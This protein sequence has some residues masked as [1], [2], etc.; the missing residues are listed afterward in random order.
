LFQS[1]P[2][3]RA[4]HGSLIV[5]LLQVIKGIKKD[6]QRSSESVEKEDWEVITPQKDVKDDWVMDESE[7]V[8]ESV[9][10]TDLGSLETGRATI[11]GPLDS[12]ITSN[13]GR[14]TDLGPLDSPFIPMST[15]RATLKGPLESINHSDS[16]P[17]SS[18][19]EASEVSS[20][21][22]TDKKYL[23][24]I[25]KQAKKTNFIDKN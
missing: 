16:I 21:V 23:N 11:K 12:E 25:A 3:A 13:I 17:S 1:L 5:S 6:E 20:L 2:F 19:N 14:V 4:W 24:F 18:N 22:R 9:R 15:G 7:C 8:F 10:A